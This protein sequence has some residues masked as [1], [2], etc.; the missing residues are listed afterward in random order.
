MTT[1]KTSV[2]LVERPV[3]REEALRLMLDWAHE[4]MWAAG[5]GVP[6]T[7][8][9]AAGR[10]RLVASLYEVLRDVAYLIGKIGLLD[11]TADEQDAEDVES[12]WEVEAAIRDAVHWF[13]TEIA[14]RLGVI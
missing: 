3:P 6:G 11:P 13:D 7:T 5:D 2:P 1:K 14:P 12:L 8:F 4:F 9:T 10:L